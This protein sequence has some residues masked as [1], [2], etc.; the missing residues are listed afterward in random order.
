M[1]QHLTGDD[2]LK[3][4]VKLM[5]YDFEVQ[6]SP[7]KNN[8]VANA[9]SRRNEAMHLLALSTV[10]IMDV[11]DIDDVVQHYDRLRSI[12]QD[13][14]LNKD[15][16]PGYTLRKDV[17]LYKDILV[18]PSTSVHK[19]KYLRELHASLCSGYLGILKTYKRMIA[20]PYWQ[21]MKGDI[22]KFVAECST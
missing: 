15:S 8:R 11:D 4:A 2:Q 3:W 16:H 9:L 14:W 1:E 17:L 10:K 18:L 21:G 5:G 12:K 19:D 6:Y 7:G 22:R 20:I 13:L